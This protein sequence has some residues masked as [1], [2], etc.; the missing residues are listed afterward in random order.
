MEDLIGK[1]AIFPSPLFA[2]IKV[3]QTH[4][5]WILGVLLKNLLAECWCMR[6]NLADNMEERRLKTS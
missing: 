5:S 3:M 2:S 6:C 4:F 1:L